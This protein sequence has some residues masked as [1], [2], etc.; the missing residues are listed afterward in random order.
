MFS[1]AWSQTKINLLSANLII[2]N[3]LAELSWAFAAQWSVVLGRRVSSTSQ[4]PGREKQLSLSL[5]FC[6]AAC[7]SSAAEKSSVVSGG[8]PASGC[9]YQQ[10]EERSY[11]PPILQWRAPGE[12][13]AQVVLTLKYTWLPNYRRREEMK[14]NTCQ[15]AKWWRNRTVFDC[16]FFPERPHLSAKE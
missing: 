16:T 5:T 2:H 14:I 13:S 11:F 4:S 7:R 6:R 9:A 15:K 8:P 1:S 3:L 12:V 10:V